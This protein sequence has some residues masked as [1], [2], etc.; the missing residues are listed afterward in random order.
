MP[1]VKNC[2]RCR[3]I[4]MHTTGPQICD[5]CKKLEDEDFEKERTFVRDFPALP[6]RKFLKKPKYLPI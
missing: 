3:R 1:E 5:A 6:F 2:R 4:F